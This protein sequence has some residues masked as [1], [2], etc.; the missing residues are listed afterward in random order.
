ML[1]DLRGALWASSQDCGVP[2][3]APRAQGWHLGWQRVARGLG[4]AWP[5]SGVPSCLTHT[6]GR[7]RSWPREVPRPEGFISQLQKFKKWCKLKETCWNCCCA[8]GRHSCSRH[9]ASDSTSGAA[10]GGQTPSPQQH[11]LPGRFCQVSQ[12][13]IWVMCP[14]CPPWLTSCGL[15]RM[16]RRP[17]PGS[18]WFSS[19]AFG[20]ELRPDSAQMTTAPSPL[21]V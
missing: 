14:P 19:A 7:S 11:F 12:I 5:G 16:M 21:R 18:G 10:P 8:C 3:V 6:A 1:C 15:Q 9:R 17:T 20:T 2:D 4:S 13:C